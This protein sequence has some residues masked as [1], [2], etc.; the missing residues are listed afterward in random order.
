MTWQALSAS[1]YPGGLPPLEVY[2]S[3]EGSP[4]VEVE[5]EVE[6]W[7][8][9]PRLP[10]MMSALPPRMSVQQMMFRSNSY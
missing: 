9:A 7:R 4:R 8:G 1:P 5:L 10:S 3:S 2:P 6:G